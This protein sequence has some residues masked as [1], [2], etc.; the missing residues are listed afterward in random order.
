MSNAESF[1]LVAVERF[2]AGTVGPKGQRTFFLQA[3]EGTTTISLNLEK[4]QVHALA[5]YIDSMMED[6]PTPDPAT[7][8]M[9]LELDD[10][11]VPVWVVGRMGGTYSE[12]A[13]RIVLWAE[14]MQPDEDDT[15]APATARF[16]VTLPQ[17]M[18]FIHHARRVVGAGREPCQFCGA[19]LNGDGAWCACAN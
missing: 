15:D 6:L 11:V 3:K 2:T 7:L 10:P 8:P 5:E 16:Q 12:E 13:D 4:Q 9:D 17:A 14:E 18:A 19:P 1:D